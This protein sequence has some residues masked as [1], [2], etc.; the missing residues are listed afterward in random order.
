MAFIATYP[1]GYLHN[2]SHI[3]S[4]YKNPIK[5]TI[6]ANFDAAAEK[7]AGKLYNIPLYEAPRLLD[8]NTPDLNKYVLTEA[9]YEIA[10]TKMMSDTPLNI[11][12]EKIQ[13]EIIEAAIEY[14]NSKNVDKF[15]NMFRSEKVNYALNQWGRDFK[16]EP[17]TGKFTTGEGKNFEEEYSI[18]Q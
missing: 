16:F 8:D 3:V 4:I 1:D 18:L 9:V 5:G 15:N 14:S 6:D 7:G 13:N 11:D 2:T 10:K 17:E 12:F